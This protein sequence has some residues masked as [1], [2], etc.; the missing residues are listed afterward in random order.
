LPYTVSS[1][2][3]KLAISGEAMFPGMSLALCLCFPICVLFLGEWKNK[4]KT[5]Q[6]LKMFLFI[7]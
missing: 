6:K 4:Q 7:V 3:G 1:R 5:N 2:D